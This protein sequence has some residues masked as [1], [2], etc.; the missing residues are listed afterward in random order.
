MRRLLLLLALCGAPLS[1]WAASPDIIQTNGV[2]ASVSNDTVTLTDV[3][4]GN[5]VGVFYL[6]T[7]AS[8]R[9]VTSVT[10]DVG[11]T[12]L[13]QGHHNCGTSICVDLWVDYSSAGGSMTITLDQSGTFQGYGIAAFEFTCPEGPCSLHSAGT[14]GV[15]NASD[16][17]HHMAPSGELDLIANTTWAGACVGSSTFGVRTPTSGFTGVT[18]NLPIQ[19]FWQYRDDNAGGF[20]DER[21]TW[22]SGDPRAS[23]CRAY[24]IVTT[25]P[26][27]SKPSMLLLGVG[28]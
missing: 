6:L 27:G 21:G 8:N 14:A 26:A 18:T 7:G 24:G 9:V 19:S 10:N 2:T 1:A 5:G 22:T 12:F 28:A 23:Q 11:D 17:T 3:T 20:T 15:S 4:P 13:S 16:T 25:A